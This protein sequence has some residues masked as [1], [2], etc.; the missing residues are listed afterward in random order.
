MKRLLHAERK[1]R[2]RSS[3]DFNREK[4]MTTKRQ[5]K[6]GPQ[7]H[8]CKKYG[9]IQENCFDHIKEEKAEQG[10]SETVRGKKQT[11]AQQSRTGYTPSSWSKGAY[12]QQG[13]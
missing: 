2:E 12:T 8:H 13:C 7:C 4:A 5:F 9:H 6:R 1:Q 3:L 11:Q 10:G